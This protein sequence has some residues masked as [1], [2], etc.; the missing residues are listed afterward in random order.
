MTNRLATRYRLITRCLLFIGVVTGAIGVNAQDA[1]QGK[2]E[3]LGYR[4]AD[5]VEKVQDYRVNGW[6]YIDS[7]HIVIYAG[8]SRRY[9]I[10]T[11]NDCSDLISAENIGFSST[12]N[13]LTKFDSLRVRGAGGFERNCPITEI[14][15]LESIKK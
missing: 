12:V 13:Y 9:L 14:H 4:Q 7:K 6:N 5:A 8:P 1:L 10:T 15:A 2:L 3:K 11:M